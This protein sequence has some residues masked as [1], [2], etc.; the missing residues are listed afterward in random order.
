MGFKSMSINDRRHGIRG[1]MKPIDEFEPQGGEQ[2]HPEEQEGCARRVRGAP[3]VGHEVRD[4]ITPAND[5]HE[6]EDG[7]AKFPWARAHFCFK[8]VGRYRCRHTADL[9]W[10]TVCAWLQVTGYEQMRDTVERRRGLARPG[11]LAA[12]KAQG[13]GKLHAITVS[14][15]A[16]S[17]CITQNLLHSVPEGH[18]N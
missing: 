12:L 16:F 13:V 3:K 17:G 9:L 2:R 18:R 1:I 11:C 8:S 6:G 10:L 7:Q 15:L 14:T 4:G 5:E